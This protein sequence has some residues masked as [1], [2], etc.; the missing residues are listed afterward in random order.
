MPRID[1]LAR[2]LKNA[3]AAGDDPAARLLAAELRAEQQREAQRNARREQL[4]AE[5]PAEYDPSSE[6]FRERYGAT[7]SMSGAKRFAAGAG[8]SVVDL[9][10]GIRQLGAE[11][12]DF[13]TGGDRAE[14]LRAQQD[15]VEALDAELMDTGAGLAGNITG[16]VA[17]TLLPAAGVARVAQG[18]NLARTATAARALANPVGY[19]A[20]A[21]A[22]AAQGALQPVGSNGSRARNIATGAAAG[23]AGRAAAG[24]VAGTAKALARGIETPNRAAA[25]LVTETLERA[26]ITPREAIDRLAELGPNARLVDLDEGLA[27]LARAATRKPSA[28]RTAAR[29]FLEERHAGQ[30]NRFIDL[31]GIG[32]VGDFI[33]RARTF[34]QQRHS[35]ASQLYAQAYEAP[36]DLSTQGMQSLLERPTMKAIMKAAERNLADEG[37]ALGHVRVMDAAKRILDDKIGAALR[38]GAKDKARRFQSMRKLLLDEVDGQVPAY[39]QARAIYAGEAAMRDSM[40]LGRNLFTTRVDLDDAERAIGAMGTG[41]LESF[42]RGVIRGLVDKLDGIS[43]GADAASKLIESPRAREVLRLAFPDEAAFDRMIRAAETESRFARTRAAVG[44]G[45][46]AA[47]AESDVI[48]GAGIATMIARGEFGRATGELLKRFGLG[49]VSDKTR[50]AVTRALF[51]TTVPG[52]AAASRAAQAGTTL[53]RG[54]RSAVVS[55]AAVGATDQAERRGNAL[56]ELD[57]RRA[58][59]F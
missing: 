19:R 23:T 48:E 8:K 36:L 53:A 56:A 43:S 42:Q 5:N 46:G 11:A 40:Q 2:A 29:D 25:R 15:D 33:S 44:R 12:L 17:T 22:G 26:N 49:K 30:R 51:G 4:R 32:D 13:V 10:R 45:A 50:A 20:A 55:G 38:A 39:A 24:V 18:A 57:A 47:N 37:A 34:M 1:Q 35:Q 54:G 27:D 52:T 58:A 21:A 59:A 28:T 41:E 3:D 6:A 14:R 16:A 31:T 7:S 9:G